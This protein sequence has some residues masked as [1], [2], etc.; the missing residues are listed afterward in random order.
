MRACERETMAK[1]EGVRGIGEAG[2]GGHQAELGL[3]DYSLPAKT[4]GKSQ[5]AAELGWAPCGDLYFQK[6]PWLRGRGSRGEAI[7]SHC[8]SASERG[9]WPGGAWRWRD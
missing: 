6:D 7:G 1:G 2:G 8:H 5:K 9:Q 3:P 4:N